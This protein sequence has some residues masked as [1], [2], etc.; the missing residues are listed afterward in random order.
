MILT[1]GSTSIS[2][3]NTT[4]TLMIDILPSQG[5]SATACVSSQI[6]LSMCLKLNIVD[7]S[8]TLLVSSNTRIGN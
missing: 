5:S 4:M 8:R 2:I 1:V 7:E 3:L 6:L